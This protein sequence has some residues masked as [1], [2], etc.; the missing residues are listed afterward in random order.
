MRSLVLGNGNMLVCLDQNG[1]VRDFYFPYVGLENHVGKNRVHKIGVW[2]DGVFSWLT[3]NSW[4]K[5]IHYTDETLSSNII[6]RNESLSLEIVFTDVVYNEKNIF[7]RKVTV[8]NLSNNKRNI[9]LFFNQ[10]FQISETEH[11]ETAYYNPNLQAVVHYKGRRVFLAGGR[12]LSE[13]PQDWSVGL[14]G[15]EG[16]EGTWK[17]AEDGIL[18]KNPIEHGAID[19]VIGFA[20]SLESQ[21]SQDIYYWIV[22]GETLREV[23]A[24]QNYIIIKTPNHLIKTTQ[25]FWHAW[26]NKRN[27]VFHGLDERIVSLF[28]KSLLII[29]THCDNRGGILASGDSDNFQYGRDTYAYIWPRD[30]AFVAQALDKAGYHEISE[31]FY[32]FCDEIIT[33]DGYVLHK[34]QPDRS[35]GSSWHPWIKDGKK[36]LA[37]QEDETA[38]ILCGLWEHYKM[39]LNLEFIESKYNSLIKNSADFLVRFRDQKTG[40]P[41][42]SYDLWEEK[43]G[44]STFTASTVVGALLAASNFAELL[45]KKEDAS[46]YKTTSEEIKYAI[47]ENLFDKKEWRFYKMVFFDKDSIKIDNTLDSASFFGPFRFKIFDAEDSCL[48]SAYEA[49]MGKLFVKD[50]GVAR[51]EGD[52][53]FRQKE[54]L[55][56]P[57]N[58][59]FITTLWFLQYKIANAKSSNDLAQISYELGSIVRFAQPS[60]IFSEQINSLSG[61]QVS[62]SPLI[63]SHAE[64]VLTTIAYMEKA[65]ALKIAPVCFPIE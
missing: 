24:L 65:E 5:S 36:Q 10:Q 64:F 62:V 17:D 45:G 52:N 54:D 29:R 8:V 51:Y 7:I 53:Y 42:P 19:S 43:F 28:K 57:G 61:A 47:I 2:V 30:A 34:Y 46:I 23:Q 18:S 63:W 59:W 3:E 60:G 58:P 37:I 12:M 26:V 56:S 11:A 38:L 32:A 1:L 27:F 13:A 55:L 4:Q 50:R 14:F 16:K 15:I 41:N 22:A 25:D 20:F 40:L 21:T 9:K 31:K 49:C 48:K 39:S 44:V 6:F 33:S 35:L